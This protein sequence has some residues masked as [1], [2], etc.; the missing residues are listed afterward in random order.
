MLGGRAA[1]SCVGFARLAGSDVP[2]V[3]HEATRDLA[4]LALVQDNVGRAR[5]LYE[6][7]VGAAAMGRG[8]PTALGAGKSWPWALAEYGALLLYS[9]ESQVG[10]IHCAL[11]VPHSIGCCDI[12]GSRVELFVHVWCGWVCDPLVTRWAPCGHSSVLHCLPV[13]CALCTLLTSHL[14]M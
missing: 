4:Q 2:S 7:L 12:F 13:D 9:G 1:G 11:H 14:S 8:G 6:G 3:I 5:G 10:A